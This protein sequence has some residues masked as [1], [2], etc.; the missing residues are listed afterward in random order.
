MTVFGSITNTSSKSVKVTINYDVVGPCNYTDAYTVKLT[1]KRRRD[2][3]FQQQ[4]HGARLRGRLHHHGDRH[5]RRDG[6]GHQISH[7]HGSVKRVFVRDAPASRAFDRSVLISSVVLTLRTFPPYYP[8]SLLF[9]RRYI[10]RSD[11][12]SIMG[13]VL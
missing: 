10:T 1:L 7:G 5:L 6:A 9:L 11:I 13:G 2:P 12:L 8:G 4:L 3:H